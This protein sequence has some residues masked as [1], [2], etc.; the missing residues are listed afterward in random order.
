ML[1]ALAKAFSE[2]FSFEQ[3]S[4]C[5][6]IR[7]QD[8]SVPMVG[9]HH[10]GKQAGGAQCPPPVVCIINNTTEYFSLTF[11]CRSPLH[12]PTIPSATSDLRV[13]LEP[14]NQCHLPSDLT[15]HMLRSWCYMEIY[16]AAKRPCSPFNPC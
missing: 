2:L 8:H 16:S 13:A 4:T 9:L 1:L 12:P 14:K 11:N 3:L 15:G 10:N 6:S 5:C 7:T